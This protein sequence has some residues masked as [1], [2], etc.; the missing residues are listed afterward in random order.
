[1]GLDQYLNIVIT[2]DENTANRN[3]INSVAEQL[4]ELILAYSLKN[5]Y[6]FAS[7]SSP[8]YIDENDLTS[9]FDLDPIYDIDG[10]ATH[11]YELLNVKGQ[12]RSYRK[13]NQIQNYFETRFYEGG[14]EA[15]QEEYNCVNTKVDNFTIDDL[16]N[17]IHKINANPTAAVAEAEFPTTDGFFYGDTDYDEFYFEQNNEL[18][19]DLIELQQ[20]RDQINCQLA[21]TPYQAIIEYSSWW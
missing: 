6:S 18:A 19:N 2:T 10:N 3:H 14:N 7:L 9:E 16:L 8:D 13:A 12:E 5:P 15:D 11:H 17:R 20:V 4:N 1:M 21:D